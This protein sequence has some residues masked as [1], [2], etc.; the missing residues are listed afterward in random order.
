MQLADPEFAPAA[1]PAP[2]SDA[3]TPARLSLLDST[4]RLFT[5]VRP[6]EGLTAVIMF[7]N[8]FLLLCAYNL[9]A[10]LGAHI[11]P[12]MAL[13]EPIG[14]SRELDRAAAILRE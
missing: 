11:V 14:G 4:L 12:Q 1:T 6:G 3:V 7:A 10:L 13:V 2:A 5:E 8:V 9:S